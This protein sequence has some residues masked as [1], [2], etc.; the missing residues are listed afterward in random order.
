[1][2]SPRA[3]SPHPHEVQSPPPPNQFNICTKPNSSASMSAPTR[4]GC[5]RRRNSAGI[6]PRRCGPNWTPS[7]SGRNG[8]TKPIHAPGRSPPPYRRNPKLKPSRPPQR[9]SRSSQCHRKPF[10]QNTF[11]LNPSPSPVAPPAPAA[12]ARSTSAA[13]AAMLRPSS[14]TPEDEITVAPPGRPSGQ[15]A[16]RKT[17]PPSAH[18]I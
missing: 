8:R 6:G 15:T 4:V 16:D 5:R 7:P 13:V 17:L 10:H 9:P 12:L 1:M 18:T 2:Q 14:M 3:A 11:R